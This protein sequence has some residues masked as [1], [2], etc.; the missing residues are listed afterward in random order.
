MQISR[1]NRYQLQEF[2]STNSSKVDEPQQLRAPVGYY[3][4]SGTGLG[5]SNTVRATGNHLPAGHPDLLT[6]ALS[7]ADSLL[8]AQGLGDTYH[9][10]LISPANLS[11]DQLRQYGERLM[12]AA[13]GNPDD[14]A[15]G[16]QSPAIVPYLLGGIPLT[17]VETL[18]DRILEVLEF[19]PDVE[20]GT[21]TASTKPLGFAPWQGHIHAPF[22]R[23]DGNV[24]YRQNYLLFH[25]NPRSWVDSLL[26]SGAYGATT[27]KRVERMKLDVCSWVQALLDPGAHHMTELAAQGR[28]PVD[29]FD[30]DYSIAV[31]R[32]FERPWRELDLTG[33]TSRVE[34]ADDIQCLLARG[35]IHRLASKTKMSAQTLVG[36]ALLTGVS[37][38]KF[39]EFAVYDCKRKGETFITADTIDQ[40]IDIINMSAAGAVMKCESALREHSI[41]LRYSSEVEQRFA[42]RMTSPKK[43][44]WSSTG[45]F[46]RLPGEKFKYKLERFNE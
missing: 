19:F 11:D 40:A 2:V 21:F 26:A 35:I 43:P 37:I 28:N 1:L 27:C 9:N 33:G 7:L 45:H 23:T 20:A 24:S 17:G 13:V 5:L 34:L 25:L 36:I 10:T 3:L 18:V 4:P 12:R 42:R 8:S 46:Y 41:T 32:V 15:V 22:E 38:A 29:V 6:G 31:Q 39:T 30:R 14:S 44:L 16:M